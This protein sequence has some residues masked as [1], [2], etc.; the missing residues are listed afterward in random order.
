[1]KIWKIILYILGLIPWTFIAS[2]MAFYFHAGK[3]LGRP[4]IY[5]RPDPKELGIYKD[6]APFVDWTCDIWLWSFFV[7]FL[8]VIAYLIIKRKE[9]EW[10]PVVVS[11]T[12]QIFAIILLF[13]GVFEW[14][15]D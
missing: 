9:I 4:P 2:I 3:I 11:A 6:Y 5:D 14:Y 8:L 7:W 10:A 12:G 15:I 13:S 1:M